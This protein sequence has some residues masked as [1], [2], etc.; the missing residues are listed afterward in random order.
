MAAAQGAQGGEGSGSRHRRRRD[1]SGYGGQQ[2]SGQLQ[3]QEPAN[4][5]GARHGDGAIVNGST[6][7][8]RSGGGDGGHYNAH[9]YHNGY[10]G[11]HGYGD[12]RSGKGRGGGRDYHRA[13]DPTPYPAPP[14]EQSLKDLLLQVAP[15]ARIAE[16]TSRLSSKASVNIYAKVL[17]RATESSQEQAVSASGSSA[18]RGDDYGSQNH[19]SL[20]P[21]SAKPEEDEESAFMERWSG[22]FSQ[23]SPLVNGTLEDPFSDLKKRAKVVWK[24]KSERSGHR[25]RYKERRMRKQQEDEDD[26][27]ANAYGEAE[28]GASV[29]Y[30]ASKLQWQPQR[31]PE[32]PEGY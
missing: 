14:E 32:E 6:K 28:G 11:G 12:R 2:A 24:N 29:V 27:D 20:Q 1:R 3:S 7:V 26:I 17:S 18:D 8:E 22:L 19:A 25:T 23:G 10:G 13:P 31:P 16:N 5:R 30:D 21:P 9:D 15:Q 4:H